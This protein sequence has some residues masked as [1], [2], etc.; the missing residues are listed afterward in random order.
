MSLIKQMTENISYLTRTRLPARRIDATE[1]HDLDT[2]STYLY[3]LHFTF[4][5]SFNLV[6]ITFT[7]FLNALTTNTNYALTIYK[8]RIKQNILN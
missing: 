6:P 8:M 4:H 5:L 1:C 2:R 3:L 7:I